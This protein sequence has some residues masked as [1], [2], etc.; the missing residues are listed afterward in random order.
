[1]NEWPLI[2]W[3]FNCIANKEWDET[4]PSHFCLKFTNE[5]FS[6]GFSDMQWFI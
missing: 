1:M 3:R 4:H 6:V 2:L 5:D